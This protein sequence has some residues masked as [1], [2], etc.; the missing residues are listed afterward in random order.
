MGLHQ[1]ALASATG[2]HQRTHSICVHTHHSPATGVLSYT[3]THTAA[4][5]KHGTGVRKMEMFISF[6]LKEV[7]GTRPPLRASTQ[8]CLLTELWPGLAFLSKQP[9]TKVGEHSSC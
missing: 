7:V 6:R 4:L 9:L 2:T 8:P 3:R 5:R 1:G